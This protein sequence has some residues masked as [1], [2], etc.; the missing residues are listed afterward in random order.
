MVFG[1][2]KR[3]AFAEFSGKGSLS[4]V[5]GGGSHRANLVEIIC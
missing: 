3:I 5:L 2:E 4:V 1:M